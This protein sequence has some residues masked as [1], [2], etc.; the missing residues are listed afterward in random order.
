[1]TAFASLAALW[2]EEAEPYWRTLLGDNTVDAA[3]QYVRHMRWS[4]PT[5]APTLLAPL[6]ESDDPAVREKAEHAYARYNERVRRDLGETVDIRVATDRESYGYNRPATLSVEMVNIGDRP[7]AIDPFVFDSDD[8]FDGA[9]HRS[10]DYNLELVMPNGD[11]RTYPERNWVAHSAPSTGNA[12]TLAPGGRIATQI[13]IRKHCRPAQPG[14]Y[15]AQ[16]SYGH[17][18]A[19][20]P[21][22]RSNWVEFVVRPPSREH[23][24]RLLARLDV[25][26]LKTGGYLAAAVAC[27]ML[28]ELGDPRAIDALRAVAVLPVKLN[29]DRNSQMMLHRAREALAKFDAPALVPTWIELLN[30]QWDLPAEQLAKLGD[31]RALAPLRE[32]ALNSD[33]VASAKA[34]AELGDDSVIRFMRWD[35]LRSTDPDNASTWGGSKALRLLLPGERWEDRLRHEHPAARYHALGAASREGRIDVLVQALEHA[36]VAVRR[37]AVR[38]LADWYNTLDDDE[39]GE[40]AMR[41]D[42]LKRALSVAEPDIRR[43][44]A[45][46]LAQAGDDSGEASLRADLHATDYAT[47]RRARAGLLNLRGAR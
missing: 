6:L 25:D 13:D 10:D 26:G 32:H 27:R 43:T 23:V 21:I 44:A 2:P 28:G 4:R 35:A 29:R 41:I 5:E 20:P 22:V 31:R 33:H 18:S 11:R 14:V 19:P 30:G 15:R 34:L 1:M 7:V 24:D 9:D 46:G 37:E 17:L 38:R 3:W 47:R 36:D 8:L 42:A 12:R 16:L 39:P 45:S 40:H